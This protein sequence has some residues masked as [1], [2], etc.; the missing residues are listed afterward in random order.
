MA[1][2]RST[3]PDE[4]RTT[5]AEALQGALV[6][7]IDLALQ[8]KQAHWN[9]VG[10]RFRSIHLQLDEVVEAA[11]RWM[12]IV[13]ERSVAIGEPPDGRAGT[14]AEQTG[15]AQVEAG[16][17]D[18]DKVVTAF[19]DRYH[20]VIARMRSRITETGQVDPVSQDLFIAMTGELEKQA[21]M[22][23]AEQ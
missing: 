16:W 12:D 9:L 5:A 14:V 17:L 3:L 6:D 20:V 11:R 10:R 23:Q 13:A 1:R 19:V 18:D 15:L 22:F 7:L 4:A 21:W 2:I 8:A